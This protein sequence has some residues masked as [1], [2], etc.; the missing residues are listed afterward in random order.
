[1]SMEKIPV[2]AVVGPTASGKTSLAVML[3]EK[4]NGE[5]ISADSMQIY[6]GMD[7]ATAKPSAE[8]MRSVR[9]HLIGHISS[10][11]KYSAARFSEEA[12]LA[13]RDITGRGKRVIIAGG[14]GLYVDSFLSG[15]DFPEEKASF[16]IR[17]ELI[18]RLN[19][20]GIESLYEELKKIDPETALNTHINNEKRVL[21]SL[22][23]Y[24]NSG[25]KPSVV[26][27]LAKKNE[28]RY[29][30]VYIGLFFENREVLYDRINRR[31]E[32]MLQNGLLD[33]AERFFSLKASETAVQAIGYKE[34]KPYFDGEIPLDEAKENLKRATRRYAKRQLTWF[35]KNPDINRI[36]RDNMSDDE[37]FSAACEI[38][39]AS[40]IFKG[41]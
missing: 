41:R 36:N 37:V 29:E 19:A 3:A 32:I 4:Y 16:E 38:T 20:E 7:I 5:V 2:L 12:A 23:I 25:E 30:S 8:E 15:L 1:M 31:V 9:H 39:D 10:A 14:T 18:R 22:E 26:R 33:E 21:R 11:E 28:S 24:Y 6:S 35:N 40:G 34:L 17:Q 13:A 27:L